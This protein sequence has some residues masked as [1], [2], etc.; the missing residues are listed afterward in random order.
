MVEEK[1]HDIFFQYFAGEFPMA[2]FQQQGGGCRESY[3]THSQDKRPRDSEIL[4]RKTEQHCKI[5]RS[6]NTSKNAHSARYIKK[7]RSSEE[8]IL[9][10][11]QLVKT[12][13]YMFS[14]SFFLNIKQSNLLSGGKRYHA[15]PL[16]IKF[17]ICYC[18]INCGCACMPRTQSIYDIIK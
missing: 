17:I 10:L 14:T 5:R 2:G 1:V 13:F 7:Q 12:L 4:Y 6:N 3:Y 8:I 9:P 18:R 16:S 11:V 15:C